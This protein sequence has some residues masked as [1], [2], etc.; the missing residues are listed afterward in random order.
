MVRISDGRM[1]GTAAGTIVVHVTPESAHAG[2]LGLVRTGDR[3]RLNVP[4]RSLSVLLDDRELSQRAG[5]PSETVPDPA[6]RGYRQLYLRAVLQADEG[7]DFDFLVAPEF[8]QS[9]PQAKP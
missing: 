1:S 5:Q 8:T 6:L 4:E 7:C 3:I 2:P 9:V